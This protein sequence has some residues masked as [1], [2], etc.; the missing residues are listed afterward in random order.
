MF[1]TSTSQS[2][3]GVAQS[4]R[5]AE[6]VQAVS[7]LSIESEVFVVTETCSAQEPSSSVSC[8]HHEQSHFREDDEVP[9][10]SYPP[11]KLTATTATYNAPEDLGIL[12]G[13][14]SLYDTMDSGYIT[15]KAMERILPKPDQKS[16]ASQSAPPTIN[17]DGIYLNRISFNTFLQTI[18]QRASNRNNGP[19][20]TSENINM[21]FIRIV[22]EYR[23]SS[24]QKGNYLQAEQATKQLNALRNQEEKRRHQTA[25]AKRAIDRTKIKAAHTRQ[26]LEF[27]DEWDNHMSQFDIKTAKYIS[28]VK[29][30]QSIDLAAFHDKCAKDTKSKP[31]KWSHELIQW[32]KRQ[33]VLAE[34]GNYA[35]AQQIKVVADAMQDEERERM[36]SSSAGSLERKEEAL[37]RKQEAEIRALLK[38]IDVRRRELKKQREHDCKRL[39]QRNR[40]VQA[41]MESRHSIEGTKLL[42]RIKLE[43]RNEIGAIRDEVATIGSRIGRK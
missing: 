19:D 35:D 18:A 31:P 3:R 37:R 28:E 20:D 30:R 43:L 15:P 42:E 10:L 12:R 21:H 17:L 5:C 6:M 11:A 22:E 36:N 29:G 7:S 34:Q 33:R 25:L 32:R 26:C 14:F 9:S 24:V 27:Q 4:K 8:K 40:N 41:A 2:A 1:D 39:I 16:M 38:R 13:I 23:Y